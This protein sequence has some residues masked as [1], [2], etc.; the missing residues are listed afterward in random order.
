MPNFTTSDGGGNGFRGVWT[1]P[2]GEGA[3]DRLLVFDEVAAVH[4][5]RVA[6]LTITSATFTD[7]LQPASMLF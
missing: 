4:R 3:K 5:A 7:T 6:G 1:A 2:Q